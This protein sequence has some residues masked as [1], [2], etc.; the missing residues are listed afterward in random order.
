MKL[1]TLT[2]LLFTTLALA[3]PAPVSRPA[4]APAAQTFKSNDQLGALVS[5]LA[6]I[7]PDIHP[8]RRRLGRQFK[9]R[10]R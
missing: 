9:Q 7:V 10:R 2:P 1:T 4:A 5:R 6:A 8:P 3:S